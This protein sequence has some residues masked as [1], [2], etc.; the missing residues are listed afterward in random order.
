MPRGDWFSYVALGLILGLGLALVQLIWL[1]LDRAP[2]HYEYEAG[3]AGGQTPDSPEV[4]GD[5]RPGSNNPS[6]SNDPKQPSHPDYYSHH[7][8]EAQRQMAKA[9]DAI[10]FWTKFAAIITSIGLIAIVWTLVETR[11]AVKAADDAVI[12]TR[13]MAHRELRAYLQVGSVRIENFFPDKEPK[14][15]FSFL[16]V[17]KTPAYAVQ[18]KASTAIVRDKRSSL[19]FG[20]NDNF[21]TKF[22]I[23]AGRKYVSGWKF[24]AIPKSAYERFEGG[25][26]D[27]LIYGVAVYRDAFKRTRRVVFLFELDRDRLVDG[28]GHFNFGDRHNRS[29]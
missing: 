22:E 28:V 11:K 7:D 21:G 1:E 6:D 29:N 27:F 18:I 17:G 16:N 12:V 8:L 25:A 2:H 3:P 4:V 13:D 5:G 20:P 19:R 26:W 10:V 9:T 24:N 23:G 15:Y 14:A